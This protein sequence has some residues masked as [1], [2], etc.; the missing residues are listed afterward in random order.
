[1]VRAYKR[2]LGRHCTPAATRVGSRTR[3][4]SETNRPFY[5][6]HVEV[7]YPTKKPSRVLVLPG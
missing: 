1:M 2:R 4:V 7:V 5:V 3:C 6:Y